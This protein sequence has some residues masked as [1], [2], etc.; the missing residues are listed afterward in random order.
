MPAIIF[1]AIVQDLLNLAQ[2]SNLKLIRHIFWLVQDLLNLA[3]LSNLKLI[4]FTDFQAKSYQFSAKLHYLVYHNDWKISTIRYWYCLILS[5]WIIKRKLKFATQ[6][7]T[8]LHLLL[9]LTL[10]CLKMIIKFFHNTICFSCQQHFKY[11]GL[12]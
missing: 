2:L 6:A 4:N 1:S 3:Q 7:D 11:S 8:Q 5:L 10:L 12:E 9:L